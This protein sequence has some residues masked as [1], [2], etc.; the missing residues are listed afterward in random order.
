VPPEPLLHRSAANGCPE[1]VYGMCNLST[2]ET[3]RENGTFGHSPQRSRSY[4]E[5]V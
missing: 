1:Q 2:Q 4:N 5:I 3:R